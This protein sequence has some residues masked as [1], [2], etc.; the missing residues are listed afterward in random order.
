M[1]RQLLVLYESVYSASLIASLS[2]LNKICVTNLLHAEKQ[3]PY[4]LYAFTKIDFI[5]KI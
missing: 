4:F 3:F 2:W 5:K 1:Y